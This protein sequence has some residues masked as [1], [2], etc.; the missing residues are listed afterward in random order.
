MLKETGMTPIKGTVGRARG[1]QA[2]GQT[3]RR[4]RRAVSELMLCTPEMGELIGSGAHAALI[5]AELAKQP[6]HA[7]L[8]QDALA[9]SAEGMIDWG[10]AWRVADR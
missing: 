3:G 9:Q 5:R 7:T 8:R 6:G 4:G 2:C 10:D 1:C